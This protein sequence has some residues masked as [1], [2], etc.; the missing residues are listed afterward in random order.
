MCA[1]FNP[2]DWQLLYRFP[3]RMHKKSSW[4]E[5]VPFAM[6]LTEM[7]HPRILVELGTQHGGSYCAFCQAI[8]ELKLPTRCYAVDTWLGDV[9]SNYYEESVYLDLQKHHRRHH[10][11]RPLL[12]LTFG[13]ALPL[14]RGSPL[15]LLR[16]HRFQP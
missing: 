5:H 15:H 2:L 14:G 6:A 16:R 10:P 3:E 7:L 8:A 13:L 1:E 4:T 12:P 9:H 11:F